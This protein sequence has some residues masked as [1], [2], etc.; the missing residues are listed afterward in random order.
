MEQQETS[1]IPVDQKKLISDN[2]PIKGD[3][4]SLSRR[5]ALKLMGLSPV[6][7][8]VLASSSVTSSE[9]H[10]EDV[11][12]KIVIVGGGAGAIMIL[13][14]LQHA[15][16]KPDITVI[17]PNETHLYQPG[18]VF[19]AAGEMTVDE[20]VLDNNDYID[21]DK[22][23][24]IKEEAKSFDPEHNRVTTT[25]GKRVDYDYLIVATG[26]QYNYDAIEGLSESDIGKNGISSVY[27]SDL[28]K[29]TAEG[30]PITWQWF[31]DVK[32]AAQKGKPRVL[33][34]Q[35]NTPIKCGGAPQK[36][37]MLNADY[38]KQAGLSADLRF[39]TSNGRLFHL[40]QVDKELRKVQESYD[41]ITH[42]FQHHL[43]AIDVKNKKATFVHAYDKEVYDE[44]F[45]THETVSVS[46]EVVMEYDFIHIV[47]PMSPPDALKDS[48]LLNE[49]GW[50]D[51]DQFTLQHKRFSNV[52]GIGD[53]NGIPMGKTGGSAR[54]HGPVI[55]EN[56]LAVMK[57]ET[58]KEKFDGYTVC[59]L[60]TEYGKILMAEFNYKGPAPTIPFLAIEKPRW[61][62]WVFDLYML[63]PMYKH[64]MLRGYM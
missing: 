44:D 5:D 25:S 54:K 18:Q 61:L 53:V 35:P 37:L 39:V 57:G 21:T 64:L 43:K 63:E 62:W 49:A 45:D 60:K 52:F 22:V 23:T 15:I 20:M 41:K 56:L 6:A 31:Q 8:S 24:W 50:L 2:L 40:P 7:A 3:E 47:P 14:R 58:P 27:L 9:L 10:A 33:F 36:I 1:S 55:T 59:P 16:S 29:G 34:T 32:A 30:G 51:V 17:A 4:H 26:V 11:S 28:A 42:Y 19:V 46:E 38:L 48:E 13:S 12:G